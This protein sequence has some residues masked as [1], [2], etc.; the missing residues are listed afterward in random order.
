MLIIE[1][2]IICLMRCFWIWKLVYC[3]KETF[4]YSFARLINHFDKIAPYILL[5]PKLIGW[6]NA[7]QISSQ[8]WRCQQSEH[9]NI[10]NIKPL[11]Y[12]ATLSNLR[13]EFLIMLSELPCENLQNIKAFRMSFTDTEQYLLLMTPVITLKALPWS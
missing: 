2:K 3:P 12:R 8:I 1:L 10:G 5:W 11:N 7:N 4:C 13:K 9:L 6:Q